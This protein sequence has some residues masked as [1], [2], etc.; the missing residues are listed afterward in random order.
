MWSSSLT[1]T[2][3][4]SFGSRVEESNDPDITRM[5]D[6][7]NVRNY[8]FV[9]VVSSEKDNEEDRT[10]WLHSLDSN[11]AGGNKRIVRSALLK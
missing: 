2:Y 6:Q 4:T 5:T 11:G 8:L 3:S 10:P 9:P 1:A 7:A